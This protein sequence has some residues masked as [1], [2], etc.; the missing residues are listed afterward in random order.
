M[1][2]KLTLQY[3]EDAGITIL[4]N[5][6]AYL[7]LCSRVGINIHVLLDATPLGCLVAM[8]HERLKTLRLILN[9][10]SCCRLLSFCD[11]THP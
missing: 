2:Y 11:A 1:N 4:R 9:G 7:S 3:S 5:G 10:G 8:C 6:R